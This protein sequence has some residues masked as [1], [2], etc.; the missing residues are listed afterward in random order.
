MG[1]AAAGYQKPI[2]ASYYYIRRRRK[3]GSESDK[4]SDSDSVKAEKEK[5]KAELQGYWVYD[6]GNNG[7]I[8]HYRKKAP[9]ITA[10]KVKLNGCPP[11]FEM[12]MGI[13][14]KRF[15]GL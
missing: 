10:G 6:K 13:M 1:H 14:L 11:I 7:R 9:N 15:L 3:P 8:V 12:G 2:I 4:N 5:E